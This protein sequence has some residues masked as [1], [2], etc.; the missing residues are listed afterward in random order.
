L[1]DHCAARFALVARFSL[2]LILLISSTM[3]GTR[4][5]KE[6]AKEVAEEDEGVV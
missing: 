2:D 3:I 5:A 4:D 1:F 6:N